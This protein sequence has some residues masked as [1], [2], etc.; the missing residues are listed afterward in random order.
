M[1]GTA[2]NIHHDTRAI[3]SEVEQNVTN[4]QTMVSNIYR[5]M[6]KSQEGGDGRDLSVSNTRT[7]ST[8]E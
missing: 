6:V 2:S 3:I 8:T 7:V 4:T 1:H 5:T